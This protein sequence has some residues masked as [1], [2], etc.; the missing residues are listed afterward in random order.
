[1]PLTVPQKTVFSMLVLAKQNQ[2]GQFGLRFRFGRFLVFYC[3]WWCS[4]N[5]WLNQWVENLKFWKWFS[6]VVG[7]SVH[8]FCWPTLSYSYH[9]CGELSISRSC[10]KWLPPLVIHVFWH[11]RFQA[12]SF[13]IARHSALIQPTHHPKL[14]FPFPKM[15]R[16]QQLG[17]T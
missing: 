1:M 16:E 14:R 7:P 15:K 4:Q 12:T 5:T 6:T 10:S 3:S 2:F 8:V 9:R 17:C 11:V 13:W